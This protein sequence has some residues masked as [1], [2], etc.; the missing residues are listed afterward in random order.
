MNWP[1]G[2]DRSTL[3]RA[4]PDDRE[5]PSS[6]AAQ[7]GGEAEGRNFE[8]SDKEDQPAAAAA[9]GG[10]KTSGSVDGFRR[11]RHQTDESAS[12]AASSRRRGDGFSP[13]Q[14]KKVSAA[15]AAIENAAAAV[16]AIPRVSGRHAVGMQLACGWLYFVR[17]VLRRGF[18]MGLSIHPKVSSSLHAIAPWQGYAAW[19]SQ[20]HLVMIQHP[21]PYLN[22]PSR[23]KKGCFRYVAN[24][25]VAIFPLTK[26]NLVPRMTRV[27]PSK[28]SGKAL[29]LTL[30]HPSR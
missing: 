20:V 11:L 9:L 18:T 1:I 28:A 4:T 19:L 23:Q 25:M 12:A 6:E 8:P 29:V 21:P 14:S 10:N 2:Q 27:P 15:A 26:K 24:A 7:D 17:I 22:E 5:A 3:E 13:P 30:K 16:A